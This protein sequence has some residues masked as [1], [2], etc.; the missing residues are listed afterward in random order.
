MRKMIPS[1]LC[2]LLKH[3]DPKKELFLSC[4]ASP[5][6]VGAVLSHMM[7]DV[8]ERQV[9]F[10]SRSLSKYAHLDKEGLAIVFRAEKYQ[11]EVRHIL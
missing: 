1:P 11:S 8:T 2:C 10:A 5:Y 9:V 7:E 4:D 6:G 3:F